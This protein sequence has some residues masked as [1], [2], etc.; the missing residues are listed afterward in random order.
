MKL[1][2]SEVAYLRA[3]AERWSDA[4]GVPDTRA[5]ISFALPRHRNS[6][7]KAPW[8]F[9]TI[10][11]KLLP[12]GVELTYQDSAPTQVTYTALT[13]EDPEKLKPQLR[14]ALM[15]AVELMQ[16]QYADNGFFGSD[17]VDPSSFAAL[18]K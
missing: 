14:K 2:E 3:V 6:A 8:R 11:Q 18:I 12:D 13:A 17:E 4:S 10:L 15:K 1:S 16:K 7:T 9:F 5:R